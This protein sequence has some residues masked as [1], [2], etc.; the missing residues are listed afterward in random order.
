MSDAEGREKARLRPGAWHHAVHVRKQTVAGLGRSTW[1]RRGNR[2]GVAPKTTSKDVVNLSRAS[3]FVA[4]L[5]RE[6]AEV[7]RCQAITAAIIGEMEE[8]EGVSSPGSGGAAPD[9]GTDQCTIWP[10]APP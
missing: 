6:L 8:R 9:R 3:A 5:Q 2:I 1:Y 7:D 10:A 4:Q